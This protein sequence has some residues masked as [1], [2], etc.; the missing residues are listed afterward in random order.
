MRFQTPLVPAVLIRRYKRFL[1][2]C[3]LADGREI[4][5]HCANPGSMMGLADPGARIWLEPNDDPKKKLKYGWRL[6]EHDGGHFTGVDTSVPNRALKDALIAGQVPGLAAPM[7]RPEVK[8]G[9]HSRIDFLLTGDGPD[10]Y[11]EV[12]SVTL[13]R[14]P[15]LAEFPDSITARGLKHLQELSAMKAQGARAVMLYLVQRTDCAR[16]TIAADI[17]PAYAAGLA[18]AAAAGVEVMAFDCRISPR[19]ITLG[20]ALPFELP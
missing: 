16:T 20:R 8:Y 10:T 11:V 4:T 19:E 3:R 2:D 18:A 17:D 7:V 5:A 13:S 9:A 12:K 1:A 14:Q 6:V 15:G